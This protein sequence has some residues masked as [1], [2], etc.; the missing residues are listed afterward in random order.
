[1]L[2]SGVLA[3]TPEVSGVIENIA[4]KEAK[5]AARSR[6]ERDD[7]RQEIRMACIKALG[8]FDASR[9]GPSP[10]AFLLR[11]AKNHLYNLSRGTLVPNNPPCT[12]CPCW[13]KAKKICTKND[14]GCE[15][16]DGYQKSMQAKAAIKHPDNLGD[17]ESIDIVRSGDVEAYELYSSIQDRLP[18][19][20]LEDFNKMIN[21]QLKELTSKRR[22]QIRKIIRELLDND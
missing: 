6:I 22:A 13:D 16:M 9:I 14:S 15:K 7:L 2:V 8:Q 5:I 3:Y 20:L 1:M 10:F 17:Y 12:R 18:S 21:G 19:H 4:N 11:C